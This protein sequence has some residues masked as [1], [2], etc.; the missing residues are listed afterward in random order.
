MSLWHQFIHYVLGGFSMA[1]SIQTWVWHPSSVRRCPRMPS[2]SRG[3]D[4][5]RPYPITGGWGGQ[6]QHL[7]P[8]TDAGD[9][10]PS[11]KANPGVA[12]KISRVGGWEGNSEG[13]HLHVPGRST[14]RDQPSWRELQGWQDSLRSLQLLLGRVSVCRVGSRWRGGAKESCP[15]LR[16]RIL[17][18]ILD[19]VTSRPSSVCPS[20]PEHLGLLARGA[21]G[22]EVHRESRAGG[23]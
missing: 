4:P 3:F 5:S 21:L 17:G 11:P 20:F 9:K 15:S 22:V 1:S 2:H 18:Q 23:S 6:V 8:T 14:G 7:N 16:S 13:V 10:S 19:L 12:P